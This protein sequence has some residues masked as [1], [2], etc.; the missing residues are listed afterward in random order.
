VFK[1]KRIERRIAKII[2]AGSDTI[3]NEY[4]LHIISHFNAITLIAS[5]KHKV[6]SFF[7]TSICM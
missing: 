5:P 2:K 7:M 4:S 6:H 3:L 1:I